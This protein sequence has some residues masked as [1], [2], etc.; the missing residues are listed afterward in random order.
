MDFRCNRSRAGDWLFFPQET[1]RVW[2]ADYD[3]IQT[4]PGKMC[5]SPSFPVNGYLPL[6]R[7]TAEKAHLRRAPVRGFVRIRRFFEFP[8]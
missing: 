3:P 4:D 5:L 7:K 8:R 1:N 6:P 2:V